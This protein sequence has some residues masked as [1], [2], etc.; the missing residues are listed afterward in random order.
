MLEREDRD[1]LRE[2]ET[3]LQIDEHGLEEA[4]QQ[5][6][7]LLY[8]VSKH[9]EMLISLRDESKQ[10]FEYV[11][12]MVDID[13]RERFLTDDRDSEKGE[14]RGRVTDKV[15]EAHKKVD[16]R[17]RNAETEMLRLSF[18]VGQFKALKEAF[19][20]RSYALKEMVGLYL[21]NYYSDVN[22]DKQQGAV[23]DRRAEEA[24]RAM[25]EVRQAARSNR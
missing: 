16:A 14:K 18:A 2:L 25:N 1:L 4:N 6:P 15:I 22:I 13:L 24:R 23:K 20:Q 21:A 12:A 5:Q 17:V 19:I 9:L 3:G 8:R 7:D 10:N 11:E